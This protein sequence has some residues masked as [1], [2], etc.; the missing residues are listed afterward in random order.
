[1][2]TSETQLNEDRK[3]VGPLLSFRYPATV[4]DAL[5]TATME[6]LRQNAATQAPE[7]PKLTETNTQSKVKLALKLRKKEYST[8]ETRAIISDQIQRPVWMPWEP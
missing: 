4:L 7:E 8:W 2:T 6:N 5:G 3:Y 1:M